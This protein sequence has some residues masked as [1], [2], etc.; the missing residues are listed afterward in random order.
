[1]PRTDTA[2]YALVALSLA[3]VFATA[4][5][6]PKSKYERAEVNAP[7]AGAGTDAAADTFTAAFVSSISMIFVSEIGDKTFFIAAIMAMRH[8]RLQIFAAALSAL[9]VMTVLSAVMGFA[10]PNLIPRAY[11][12][13]AACALFLV[14]G[15][16]LLK[17]VLEGGGD[18][19]QVRVF[20]VFLKR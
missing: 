20:A 11:T 10:L 14:F 7:A 6:A 17:D 13:Y 4:W 19:T 8:N 16:R 3:C 1:M 12:H 9:I 5:A 2:R 15:V 18:S